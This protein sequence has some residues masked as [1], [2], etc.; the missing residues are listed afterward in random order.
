MRRIFKIGIFILLCSQVF[1]GSVT[2]VNDSANQ[3][4]AV[5]RAA[6]GTYI[7]EVVVPAR[8]TMQWNDYTGGVGN[9]QYPSASQTPYTVAWF[10]MTGDGTPFS[11]CTNV[12]SGQTITALTCDGLRQCQPNPKQPYP[13]SKGSQAE[14][15]LQPQPQQPSQ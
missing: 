8:Q 3:L 9:I 13:P 5:I 14:N 1:A 15:N 4:R 11:I 10:C 12:N 7:G 2:L 6:D